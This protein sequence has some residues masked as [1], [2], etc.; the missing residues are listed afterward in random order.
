MRPQWFCAQLAE[1]TA[2]P[3]VADLPQIPYDNMWADDI[4]WMPQLLRGT[5]FAGRMDFA[6]NGTLRKWWVAKIVD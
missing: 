6:K 3:D 5:P 2:D 4:Y 1:D